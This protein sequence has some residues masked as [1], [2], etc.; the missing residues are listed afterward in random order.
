MANPTINALVD[1]AASPVKLR[2][3]QVGLKASLGSRYLLKGI[4]FRLMAG[5]RLAIVGP[6]GAGK[7]SLLRLM[8]RLIDPHEGQIWYGDRPLSAYPVL[9]VRQSIPLVL[10]EPRLLGMTVAQ[11]LTYPLQ[12]RQIPAD[13]SRDRLHHWTE[14]LHIPSDWLDRSETQLSVG[15]RQ[16][17]SIARALMIHPQ[18]LLLDEPTA[19]LDVGRRSHL[20]A[21]L[22]DYCQQDGCTM[23]MVSHDLPTAQAFCSKLL[24]L[25]EGG[26]V[27]HTT[28]SEVD[29]SHLHE[30]IVQAEQ[31]VTDWDD[32]DEA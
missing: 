6:S 18:I 22:R 21:V 5:D 20:V 8:N 15:Q 16:L 1:G 26:I 14:R 12:L 17:V 2:F 3:E 19:A 27:Q 13:E 30:A 25:V 11:T 7:T 29:W 28:H 32:E 24:Y 23:V 10:Q 9:K 4:T 31:Q